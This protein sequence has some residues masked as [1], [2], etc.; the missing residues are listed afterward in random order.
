MA[1]RLSRREKKSADR[2]DRVSVERSITLRSAR[3]LCDPEERATIVAWRH[4]LEAELNWSLPV[5]ARNNNRY[6][7]DGTTWEDV[8]FV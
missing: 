6:S 4:L 3:S 1:G 5:G 8:E 2:V 7:V